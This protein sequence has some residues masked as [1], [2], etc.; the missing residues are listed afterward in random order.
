MELA[1][2]NVFP[3]SLELLFR[4]LIVLIGKTQQCSQVLQIME[5]DLSQS[6]KLFDFGLSGIGSP[7]ELEVHFSTPGG[8]IG[9]I[10]AL[11]KNIV[12]KI[13]DCQSNMD[14]RYRGSRIGKTTAPAKFLDHFLG[15]N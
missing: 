5:L 13:V 12:I 8:K 1:Q 10:V 11:C 4:I 2:T 9:T 15:R 14:R 3:E 6:H 7:M